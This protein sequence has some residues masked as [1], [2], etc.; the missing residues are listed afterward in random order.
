MFDTG[1]KMKTIESVI[2][3][4]LLE[5]QSFT[6]QYFSYFGKSHI[7]ITHEGKQATIYVEILRNHPEGLE[8][9]I[10]DAILKLKEAAIENN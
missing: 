5:N 3:K 6:F 1:E 10:D 8:K 4:A 2:G 7:T 9:C